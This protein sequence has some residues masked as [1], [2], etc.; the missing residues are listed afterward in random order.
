MQA[1]SYSSEDVRD[2]R[3]LARLYAVLSR[4]N[5]AIIRTTDEQTIFEAACKIAVDEGAFPLAWIGLFDHETGRLHV[6]A[7][8]G[9]DEDYLDRITI[10]LDPNVPEGQ[11]PTA[12]SLRECRPFVNNDTASNPVMGPWRDEQLKRGFKSS[13]SFPLIVVG[14]CIGVITLY[15]DTPGYFDAQEV[16]LLTALA[17]DFSFALESIETARKRAEAEASLRDAYADLETRVQ[18]RTQTLRQSERRFR[19]LITATH[20]VVY[21]M[22]PDWL[23]MRQLSGQG[24]LADTETDHPR[25]LQQYIP[26]SDRAMVL[27]AIATVI[28]TKGVFELEHRVVRADGTIGWVHSRAVPLLDEQG[29]ISEWFGF[30]ID[31]SERVHAEEALRRTQERLSLALGTAKMGVW[32]WDQQAANITARSEGVSSVLGLAQGETLNSGEF[33]FGLVH[34]DDLDHYKALVQRAAERNEGWHTEFR[35]IRPSDGNVAW[36][37]EVATPTPDPVTGNTLYTGLVRDVTERKE[38]EEQ[39][40]QLLEG[41]QERVRLGHSMAET[42]AELA[43]SLALEQTLPT[44]LERARADVGARVVAFADRAEDGWRIRELVGEAGPGLVPGFVFADREAPTLMRLLRER[45][46][47]VVPDVLAVENANRAMAAR[48]GYRAYV[49]QPL[50]FHDE[51]TGALGIFF[52]EP[53]EPSEPELDY[54]RRLAFAIS[55]AEESARRYETEHDIAEILQTALL[56]LPE[57]VPGVAF[58]HAYHS[59]SETAQVGGDFYDVFEMGRGFVGVIVGDVAGKGLGASTLTSLVKNAVRAYASENGAVPARIL[60]LTNKLVFESTLSE[61]FVTVFFGVVDVETGRL[62]YANAGHTTGA[63][64]ARDGGLTLMPATGPVIGAFADMT[65]EQAERQLGGDETMFL[66]TDGL[67]EARS[68]DELFGEDRVFELLAD[69]KG[70]NPA[71]LVRGMIDEVLRFAGGHLN[72]D[73]AIFALRSIQAR[74]PVPAKKVEV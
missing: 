29:D 67:T 16:R 48:V 1:E 26:E 32:E 6:A 2:L 49:A 8:A 60:E 20:D 56:S 19:T 22:S 5:E 65:F 36:L 70:G 15:A 72:D 7:K 55:L 43:S 40:Q 52:T 61:S 38:V 28:P 17:D 41:E 68:G 44:V 42:N 10:S 4:V 59:A 27:A 47:E 51:V 14:A 58:A 33:G 35:I 18:E 69:L 71:R 12:V 74:E 54:I 39:R 3:R 13:A 63:L 23:V 62:V 53:K 50:I 11:G 9:R 31:I 46:R 25:W 45:E 21:R 73:L 34:P 57:A 24:F 30:A 64:V 66:Y 37:E